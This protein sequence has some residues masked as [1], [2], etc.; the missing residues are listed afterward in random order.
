[1]TPDGTVKE[2]RQYVARAMNDRGI[3][4]G[5]TWI[6]GYPG[7]SAESMHAT[8]RLAARMLAGGC[9]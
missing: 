5:T 8:I 2:F 4:T 3:Q 7:E 6:I 1:M 9:H